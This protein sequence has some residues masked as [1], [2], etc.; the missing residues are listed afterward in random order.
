MSEAKGVTEFMGLDRQ[1]MR[2]QAGSRSSR[3]L[4][5]ALVLTLGIVAAAACEG[6]SAFTGDSIDLLPRVTGVAV[7]QVANAGDVVSVGVDA[8]GA[9][10]ITRLVVA[11]RGSTVKDTAIN[12]NPPR[13]RLSEVI[14]IRLPTLLVD[15]LLIVQA[16]V[17]DQRGNSSQ[18]KEGWGVV[19]GPPAVTDIS[20]PPIAQAGAP[21]S[22]RVSARGSRRISAVDLTARGA[23][24]LDSLIAVVPP[25]NA[26]TQDI[27]LFIPPTAGDTLISLAIGVR[28]EAGR[29]SDPATRVVP[30]V[31]DPPTVA[32]SAPATARAGLNMNVDVAAQAARRVTEIRL[33]IRGGFVADPSVT[34]NPAQSSVTQ[35]ITVA[36]PGNITVGDLQIRAIA[37]DRGGA[38]A[39]SDPQSVTIPIGQPVV[40]DVE[41]PSLVNAGDKVDVRVRAQG[42]RPLARV[43]L[44]F[45]GA[46]DSDRVFTVSPQRS[47]VVLDASVGVGATPKDSLLI[48]SATVTD[49]AGAVSEIVTK[50]IPVIVP[51]PAI[52]G[53]EIPAVAWDR[54]DPAVARSRAE[55]AI[56][57]PG[58]AV[59]PPHA[60]ARLPSR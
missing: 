59:P 42:D 29:S 52:G 34:I 47:D 39:Y 4:R 14:P 44:W 55:S 26:V 58:S 37:I 16:K 33:E 30:L 22:I 17:V 10:G 21:I 53:A 27:I 23:V 20:A 5:L 6:D 45:R 54:P 25:R 12:F 11:V 43:D 24:E 48:V 18:A 35:T 1:E 40:T 38:V 3:G 50:V 32:L 9:H 13:T 57:V 2:R 46:V 15:T 60:A 31:I 36:V 56:D 8:T 51:A 41:V 19:V 49:A 28:D 7:P